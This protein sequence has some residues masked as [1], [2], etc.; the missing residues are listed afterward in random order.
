MNL[1]GGV[2]GAQQPCD[3]ALNQHVRAKYGMLEANKLMRQMQSG[4]ALPTTTERDS[5][6][7]LHEIWNGPDSLD[8]H[9]KAA[10]G[11]KEAG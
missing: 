8:L 2:T 3:G 4:V 9:K 11:F 6:K 1:G 7:I 10:R 5:L